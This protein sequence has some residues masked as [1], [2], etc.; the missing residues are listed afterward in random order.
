MDNNPSSTDPPGGLPYKRRQACS[1]KILKKAPWERGLKYFITKRHHFRE[2]YPTEKRNIEVPK[3]KKDY[4]QPR[5]FIMGVP[6][7]SG[8]LKTWNTENYRL[9][10]VWSCSSNEAKDWLTSFLRGVIW[11]APEWILSLS[12]SAMVPIDVSQ[13]RWSSISFS[14]CWNR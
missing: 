2:K 9:R 6:P 3:P 14:I 7:G 12:E 13:S 8:L 4:K 10:F 11:T 1:S 5:L